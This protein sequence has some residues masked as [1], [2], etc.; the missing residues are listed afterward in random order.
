[1]TIPSDI[2]WLSE[3]LDSA[4]RRL[5]SSPGFSRKIFSRRKP[6]SSSRFNGCLTASLRAHR[7]GVSPQYVNRRVVVGMGFEA[8]MSATE[9]RLALA[10]SAVNGSAFRTRLARV[11]GWDFNQ[12]PAAIFKF[13]GKDGFER[14]PALIED[15]SIEASL[16]ANTATWGF[17]RSGRTRGHIGDLQVLHDNRSE[18]ARDV[19]RGAVMPIP[20]DTGALGGQSGAFAELPQPTLGAFLAPRK[21]ALS[22]PVP[23]VYGRK[24]RR[25]GQMLACRERKRIGY[26]TV[27][28]DAWADVHRS[29]IFDLTGKGNMP[30]ECIEFD[31][32]VIDRPAKWARVKKLYPSDFRQSHNAPLA[33]QALHLDFAALKA[34]S[35]VYPSLTWR[36]IAGSTLEEIAEGF[37]QIQQCLL[38]AGLRNG[39]DPIVLR[40]QSSQFLRLREIAQQPSSL[41][42]ILPPEV[43]ALLKSQ[44]IDQP[45]HTSELLEQF[46][47]AGSGCELIAEATMHEAILSKFSAYAIRRLASGPEG[48]SVEMEGANG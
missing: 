18:P 7:R 1:M 9:D 26:A 33:V 44:I 27:N 10:T 25:D 41:S 36:R 3:R 13:V 17:N 48:G 16:R 43:T 23:T 2:A 11:S 20:A 30:A 35:V 15:R 8:T 5:T 37:I 28:A 34:E 39:S 29:D 22:A 47:L 14:V 38:L 31:C 19:Q 32:D 6:A 24:A 12:R 45:A 4:T 21:D 46:S 40:S 42:L